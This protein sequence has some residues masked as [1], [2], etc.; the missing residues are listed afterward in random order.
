MRPPLNS[1]NNAKIRPLE[2][3]PSGLFI[4]RSDWYVPVKNRETYHRLYA[5]HRKAAVLERTL[6]V[7]FIDLP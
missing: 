3:V 1:C 5:K 7:T 6:P 2:W 4:F